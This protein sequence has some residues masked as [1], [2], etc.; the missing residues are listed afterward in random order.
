MP[1]Y[2]ILRS[3][4]FQEYR[5]EYDACKHEGPYDTHPL[6]NYSI[7]LL[8]TIEKKVNELMQ[9]GWVCTGGIQVVSCEGQY[10]YALQSMV[11]ND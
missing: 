4:N 11:K 3:R 8:K 10:E 5:K 6:A 7:W 1:S 2:C 9:Q